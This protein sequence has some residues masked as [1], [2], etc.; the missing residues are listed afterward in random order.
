MNKNFTPVFR[1]AFVA[2]L[3]T[4]LLAPLAHA[5]G[6][7]GMDMKGMMK[8]NNEQMSTMQATGNPDVDFA[9][10]MRMHHMGAL[11]MAEHELKNGKDPK[12]RDMAKKIMA[13][14]KK[15]IAQFEQFLSKHGHPVKK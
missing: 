1:G 5:Q 8:E 10:M 9:M 4:A 11:P 7:G 6:Q 12:M 2:V 13:S 3:S 14:Q 15:E